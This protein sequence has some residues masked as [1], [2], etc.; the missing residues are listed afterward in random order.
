M[1]YDFSQRLACAKHQGGEEKRGAEQP[2]RLD[3]HR[4]ELPVH[5]N[6]NGQKNIRAEVASRIFCGHPN[7]REEIGGLACD[8]ARRFRV[9][10][11]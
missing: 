1:K 4:L 2:A 7:F 9:M 11:L 6:G 3:R 8:L 5:V 10:V